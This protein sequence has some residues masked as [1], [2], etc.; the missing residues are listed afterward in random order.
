MTSLYEETTNII[1]ELSKAVTPKEL[2]EL[3]N[4]LKNVDKQAGSI[5]N[6]R[7]KHKKTH[8]K[9]GIKEEIKK[10]VEQVEQVEQVDKGEKINENSKEL[11]K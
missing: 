5:F 7:N 11:E 8:N 1:E 3:A 10:E 4:C 6:Y 2:K 9:N